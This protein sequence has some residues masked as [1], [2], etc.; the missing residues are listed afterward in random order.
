MRTTSAARLLTTARSGEGD[1]VFQ[2]AVLLARLDDLRRRL[3]HCLLA[4]FL[5]FVLCFSVSDPMYRFLI[6][7]LRQ[8]LPE[9]A[10]L[11][12]TTIPEIFIVHL[13]IGLFGAVFLAAP[14]WLYHLWGFVDGIYPLRKRTLLPALLMG[15]ALF[16]GGAAF[17]HFVL[18]PI[19]AHFFTTF[20]SSSVHV[21]LSVGTVFSFYMQFVLGMGAAFQIPTIVLVL[22]QLRL[23]TPRFLVRHL[24]YVILIVFTIAAILTPTPDMVTQS[25]LALPML[26][27]YVFSIVLC[28]IMQRG[29][30]GAE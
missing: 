4:L 25:L 13:Q 12:A 28:W 18:F 10:A 5:G 8:A 14:V 9:G 17:G 22:S 20:G 19:A 2:P 15:V 3:V 11:V 1:E 23:V 21:L 30:S 26:G 7:P 27:L 16:L 6:A 29:R 24:K